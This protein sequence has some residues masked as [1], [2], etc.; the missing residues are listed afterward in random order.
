MEIKN[1]EQLVEF[2]IKNYIK[3]CL[4]DVNSLNFEEYQLLTQ[5]K[6]KV[7]GRKKQTI[8]SLLAQN[9]YSFKQEKFDDI[10]QNALYNCL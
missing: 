3:D 6:Q 9:G 5:L 7:A 4:D 8:Q 2:I 10:F 1:E